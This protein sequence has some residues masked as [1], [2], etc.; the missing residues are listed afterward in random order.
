MVEQTARIDKD[1][2]LKTV[3]DLWDSWYMAGLMDFI[4]IPNLTPLVDA[5]YKTNGLLEKA[6]DLVDDYVNKLEI[7]GISREIFKIPAAKEGDLPSNPLIVYVIEPTEGQERNIMLYG[8]LDKQPYEEPWDEGLSPTDPVIKDGRLY[9]RGGSDDG[10]AVFSCM[11]AVKA[12]QEQ[13][14][15]MPRVVM[16]LETEEESGSDDLIALLKAAE[17]LIQ[18]P[19]CCFCMDS[20]CLDYKQLWVT[21]SLRGCAMVDV[22]V[23]CAK[24]GYHSGEVG[25]IVPETF[26]VLR[27]LLDRLDDV[28]T[29]K[30]ASEFQPELPE[31]KVNEA[32]ELA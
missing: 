28:E 5:E 24:G 2:T 11:L 19:D 12:A 3:S 26:R 6:I 21:S 31:W 1:K 29:G 7:K 22:Q 18:E 17:P 8:H 32:K 15:P 30:V 25:G 10:Y 4:R 14:V 23:E 9:G 20:G 13:G 27:V 16:V